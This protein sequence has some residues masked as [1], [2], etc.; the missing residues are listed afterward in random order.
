MLLDTNTLV[1]L[2]QG[3]DR[4]GKKALR[5]IEK[6][7]SLL[8]SSISILELEIK[9][10]QSHIKIKESFS[11]HLIDSGFIEIRF[12][13]VHA[14]EIQRFSSLARHDPFDRALVATASAE[15][16]NFMTSDSKLLAL[17]FDF[18]IDAQI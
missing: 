2:N 4:L 17:G 16:I 1:W 18:I 12:G 6:A 7:E 13:S 9:R 3:S 8:F 10:M 5:D 14:S 15:K 11:S